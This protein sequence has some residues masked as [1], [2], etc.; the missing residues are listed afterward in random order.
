MNKAMTILYKVHNNLYVNLTNK[1]PCACTFCVRQSRDTVSSI[2]QR[3]LWLEREPSYEE[4]TAEFSKYDLR[5]FGELV[6]CGYGEPTER[7]DVLLAVASYAKE[8]FGRRVRVNTNGM[9][10]LI[11]GRDTTPDFAGVVDVVSISLN[12]PDPVKYQEVVRCR[13]GE[14]SFPAMLNFAKNVRK[15]VPEVVLTTVETV[16]SREEEVRC[17]EIC[18]E[19]GVSYRIRP[20]E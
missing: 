7:L 20:W 9:A 17:A 14:K 16:L 5:E 13:F 11:W 1:C 10:D 19:I 12:S 6:F 8:H 2:D 18:R 3:S 15:Y 4:V